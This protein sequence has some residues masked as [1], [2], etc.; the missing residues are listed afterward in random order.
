MC[1][2]NCLK[3]H[4]V[5]E[6]IYI[7]NGYAS[8]AFSKM[9]T[10]SH[11]ISSFLVDPIILQIN[12]ATL[13]QQFTIMFNQLLLPFTKRKKKKNSNCHTIGRGCNVIYYSSRRKRMKYERSMTPLILHYRLAQNRQTMSITVYKSDV[14]QRASWHLS[15]TFV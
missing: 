3:K 1:A 11:P 10:S 9:S 4:W 13:Q 7:M 12:N 6:V 15:V 5:S 2:E 8:K 14:G